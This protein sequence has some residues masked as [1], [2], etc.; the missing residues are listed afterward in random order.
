MLQHAIEHR[1]HWAMD[2]VLVP[3]AFIIAKHA[4]LEGEERQQVVHKVAVNA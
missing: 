3:K 4:F 2:N 1:T